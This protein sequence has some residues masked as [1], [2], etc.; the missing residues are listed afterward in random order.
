MVNAIEL[1]PFLHNAP[2]PN[3]LFVE[4]LTYNRP[5]FTHA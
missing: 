3:A 4:N 1:N 2:I 5:S